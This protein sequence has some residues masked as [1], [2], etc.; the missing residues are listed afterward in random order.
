MLLE[1]ITAVPLLK[2]PPPPPKVTSLINPD[3]IYTKMVEHY[4]IDTPLIM[5]LFHCRRD[6]PIR[7]VGVGGLLYQLVTVLIQ[8]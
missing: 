1:H 2:R 8:S 5:S 7:G 6:C 3:I 4:Y